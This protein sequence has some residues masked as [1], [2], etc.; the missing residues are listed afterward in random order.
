MAIDLLSEP[1]EGKPVDL[2]ASEP[3][4]RGG[5]SFVQGR[6]SSL[7]NKVFDLFSNPE[8]ERAK[9][10]N[11]LVDAEALNIRP[12]VA[13]DQKPALDKYYDI[14]P[15][16]KKYR[17][18]VLADIRRFND[19]GGVED[20][21]S[22]V[23]WNNAKSVPFHMQIAAGG[24]MKFLEE[25]IDPE[26]AMNSLGAIPSEKDLETF[27]LAAEAREKKQIRGLS[28]DVIIS[29]RKRVSELQP[30]IM[31]GSFKDTVGMA[32]Q[33][34]LNNLIYLAP[35]MWLGRAVPL[36]G[37]GTQA[38]GQSYIEQR[39]GGSE[40]GTAT[41]AAL[42]KAASEV[43][44]EFIPVGIYL[45]PRASF[46]RSLAA[47]ELSEIPT[48]TVNQIVDDVVDKVT[49]RPDMTAEEAIANIMTTVQVTALS[50]PGISGVTYSA[51]K[52]LGKMLSATEYADT[53][54]QAK[55]DALMNGE[56]PQAAIKAGIDAVQAE[57]GG[58]E[59]VSDA[60]E[61]I[62]REAAEYHEPENNSPFIIG[63]DEDTNGNV[64]GFTM[65]D[66]ATGNTFDVPAEVAEEKNRVRI[67]PNAEA[68]QSALSVQRENFSLDIAHRR[69]SLKNVRDYFGLTDTEFMSATKRRNPY[70]MDEPEYN[71][72]LIDVQ[73]KAMELKETRF[74]KMALLKMIEAKRLQKVD[75][76]R[77]ALQ[78]PAFNDMNA[79]QL[80][81][82]A[83]LLEPF[84]EDDVFLTQRELETVDRTDLK[85]VKT[86]REARERLAKEAGVDVE[87]LEKVHVAA[88]DQFR[89]DSS[90]RER[91]PFF[92][93]MVSRMTEAGLGAGLRTHELENQVYDLARKSDKSRKLGTIGRLVPQD[94]LIM[95]FLEAPTDKKAAIVEQMTPEQIN[96][97]HF[98]QQ[99]FADALNYLLAN[100]SL[101]HGRENYFVHIRKTFLEN[102]KD[103]GFKKAV[104][105]LFKTYE[106]DQLVFNILDDNTGKILPLEK[107]FQ[108]SMRR[109]DVMD[110]SRNVTKA[111]LTYMRTFERKK[112][113]DAIIPKLDI[114]A[115][116]LTPTRYTPRG[117]EI[118]RSLK[119]FVNKWIN[120][121][122][123]RRIS[124]DS[125]IRQGGPIDV[126]IRAL[127]T[128]TTMLDLGL[129]PIAQTAAVLGEQVTNATMLGTRGMAL[130]TSR[131]A[132]DKGKRIIDK[133]RSFVGRSLWENFTAP[134]QE[135]T[136]R[137][138]E[139]LFSGFHVSS[140]L[141]NKQFLLASM[142]DQEFEAEE[143]SPERLAEMQL[144]MGRFRV[145]PGTGSL[146]GST[147]A[148][149][150]LM[151]Y[152]KWAVPLARTLITDGETLINNMKEGK[153]FD[154]R[155]KKE[156][157]RFAYLTGAVFIVGAMAGADDKE[158]HSYVGKAKARMYREAMTLT[159]GM[160]PLLF[161]G[162][163]RTWTWV[164][165]T[166]KALKDMVLL[167]EYKTKDE[168][169]G[170][171]ELKRQFVPGAVRNALPK[172][173]D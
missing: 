63:I 155:A 70:L 39:E 67:T 87:E 130:G 25:N 136:E 106:Q 84:Q 145:V 92:D 69:E 159:Q 83:K 154:E 6:D 138:S 109:S 128:F 50:T 27:R 22:K 35:G 85:G 140:V 99:Y 118:D 132:T 103:G 173:E 72:F 93:I 21:W 144:D 104:S 20:E 149:D 23:L 124:F 97:A 115:Q 142:T 113:F 117:L 62:R 167:E 2:L 78:L 133:Y 105:E 15:E 14:A 150:A 36:I 11:A 98:M 10:V 95:A 171:A 165:D 163:P 13:Y 137:L 29:G 119:T 125:V 129:S 143:V 121:K 157:I 112:M 74:E 1:I 122:K 80:R 81:D 57:P 43:G 108:F 53:F 32:E 71:R 47:A 59:T 26:L 172:K 31:P 94:D 151:Q 30:V 33:S 100:K 19:M 102:L 24:V 162:V 58:A 38:F 51:N 131:L 96:Y 161:I 139:M 45:K 46:V 88:L 56:T 9:A 158:D 54:N 86:W 8:K 168:L 34:T 61:S 49:I 126:G 68:V 52:A 3:E 18:K 110:P 170:P 44:T 28:D 89:W 5:L 153:P 42:V 148:G 147:S 66:P 120:N 7:L 40:T 17:E 135:V 166:V 156:L 127:R 16:N 141:A 37:M 164:V 60:V 77:R 134:G 91:D 160:N 79:Q 4:E 73:Q 48:E 12:F 114:Y 64:T 169:K 107:F 146:V 41:A 111:F 90:L 75:N 123:G 101:E 76:F 55:N 82:F 152:K 65:A 116:A